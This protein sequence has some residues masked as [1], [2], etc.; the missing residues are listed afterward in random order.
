ML[1]V[2][3]VPDFD[4]SKRYPVE[5][6][7]DSTESG[8][9]MKLEHILQGHSDVFAALGDFIQTGPPRRTVT[10]LKGNHD[11]ELYW[12]RFQERIRRQLRATGELAKLVTF[13]P[14]RVDREGIYIE[15][16]NQHTERVNQFP[17]FAIPLD[18]EDP[19]RVYHPPGSRFVY[20]FFNDVE[21]ERYWIDGVHPMTSLIWYGL[22]FDFEFALHTLYAFLSVAPLLLKGELGLGEGEVPEDPA[23]TDAI[24]LKRELEDEETVHRWTQRYAQDPDFRAQFNVRVH[25]A[26]VASG[27]EEALPAE[28]RVF[29]VEAA[30]DAWTR[31]EIEAQNQNKAL[32]SAAAQVATETGA[33]VV[34]FGHI[35]LAEMVPLP[36]GATYANTGTWVW[37]GDFSQAPRQK[38]A[39]LFR[40][41]EKYSQERLLSYL[42]IDY[43]AQGKPVPSLL[44]V[45]RAPAPTKPDQ[46][47][48]FGCLGALLRRMASMGL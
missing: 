16:G 15:H 7:A 11:P 30:L 12:P 42:R 4:P 48:R 18:P 38:W 31:A 14:V 10:I 41:P 8:A 37:R 5:V 27:V 34:I 20:Q 40:H 19:D 9:L 1:Q 44:E 35:H 32:A 28:T 24:A 36:N 3:A 13:P 26:L 17:D 45:T 22:E 43:D 29:E 21:R 6:Y 46:E 47:E 39:D 2:P 23:L 25:S 33:Q